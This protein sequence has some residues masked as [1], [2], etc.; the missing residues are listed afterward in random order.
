MSDRDPE[1]EAMLIAVFRHYGLR[2]PGYGERAMKCPVH[3]EDNPSCSVNRAKGLWHCHACGGGGGAAQIVMER[4]HCGY[5][6]AMRIMEGWGV[7]TPRPPF[8]R[9]PSKGRG[10]RWQP[11]QLRETG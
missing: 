9:T 4:E 10:S 2:E 6:E 5:R 3:D 8:G 7:D 11:R 1:H